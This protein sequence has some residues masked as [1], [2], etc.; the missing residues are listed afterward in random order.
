MEF[1]SEVKAKW[2]NDGRKMYLLEMLVFTDSNNKKWITP[3][4]TVVDGA[5]IPKFLWHIIGSPFVGKYRRATVIHDYYCQIKDR[6]SKETHVVLY[7]AMI[8]DGVN[9]LKANLMY[10]GVK[11]FGPDW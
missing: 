6:S 9:K 8:C 1:N 10:Y 3:R 4:G 2:L 5:S 7:Q 11:I